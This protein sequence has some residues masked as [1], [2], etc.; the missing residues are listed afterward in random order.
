MEHQRSS[1]PFFLI[2]ILMMHNKVLK[3]FEICVIAEK[4]WLEMII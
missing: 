3:R 2:K 1:P 4:N